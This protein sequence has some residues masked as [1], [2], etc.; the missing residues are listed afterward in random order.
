MPQLP[1]WLAPADPAAEWLRGAQLGAQIGSE[2]ARL[3]EE[4]TRAQMESQARQATLERQTQFERSRIATENARTQALTGLQEQR[5]QQA[6]AVVAE[7]SRQAAL[8]WAAQQSYARD[9]QSGLSAEQALYKN[10]GLLTPAALKEARDEDLDYSG[11]MLDLRTKQESLDQQKLLDAEDRANKPKPGKDIS[12]TYAPPSQTDWK[13]TGPLTAMQAQFGTNLPAQ[14]RP[15]SGGIPG[16]NAG[17]PV[18]TGPPLIT[19]QDQYDSLPAGATY[20]WQG[21]L[22][23]KAAPKTETATT[24]DAGDNQ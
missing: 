1:D 4:Q 6:Q 23:K 20:L 19:S 24:S 21:K 12:V 14:F 7:R 11:K 9:R 17:T 13:A 8:K 3:Q 15:V 18:N 5:L 10:P 22:K 16:G 2:R